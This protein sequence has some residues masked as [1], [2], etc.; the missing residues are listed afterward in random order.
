[1]KEHVKKKLVSDTRSLLGALM[2]IDLNGPD[3]EAVDALKAL[4]LESVI[5]IR[6]RITR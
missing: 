4:F 3:I 6:V 1:M 5:V 2:M